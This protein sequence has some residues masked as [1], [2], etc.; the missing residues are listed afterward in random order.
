MTGTPIRLGLVGAGAI[1]NGLGG[2]ATPHDPKDFAVALLAREVPGA[3]PLRWRSDALPVGERVVGVVAWQ[4]I[5]GRALDVG[6]PVVQDCAV[7]DF[8]PGGG[9]TPVNYLTDCDL[10]PVG[11][12]GHILTNVGGEWATSGIFSTSGGKLS[13]GRSFSRRL[14]SYTRAIGIDGGVVAALAEAVAALRRSD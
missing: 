2:T 8:D 6:M 4:E 11:S 14:G 3:R 1:W 12:G 13:V 10:G 7:R 5:E 9:E